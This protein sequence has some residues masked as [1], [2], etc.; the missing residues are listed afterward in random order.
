M[1][2]RSGDWWCAERCKNTSSALRRW[3]RCARPVLRRYSPSPRS[4]IKT[5]SWQRT[6]ATL[7]SKVHWF[8]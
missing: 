2:V 8:L 6:P 3:H 7:H 5:F 1:T 4:G